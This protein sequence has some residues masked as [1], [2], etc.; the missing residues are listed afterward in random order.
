MTS[1][2]QPFFSVIVPCYERPEDLRKCLQSLSL[3][4]QKMPLNMKLS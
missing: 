3:E 1:T 2:N 4:N